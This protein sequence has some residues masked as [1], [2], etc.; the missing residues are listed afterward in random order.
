M[1]DPTILMTPRGAPGLNMRIK[2][3]I[4]GKDYNGEYNRSY[5]GWLVGFTMGQCCVVVDTE[6]VITPP[7][8]VKVLQNLDE[9]EK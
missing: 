3:E 8:T 5:I 6:I 2:V 1:S 7:H 9:E 4:T